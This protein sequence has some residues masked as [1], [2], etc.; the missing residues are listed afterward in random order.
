MA[1][2]SRRVGL[3]VVRLLIT[4]D[5]IPGRCRQGVP[6]A[7]RLH[8]AVPRG[9]GRGQRHLSPALREVHGDPERLS[10]AAVVYLTRG[11]LLKE[12]ALGFLWNGVELTDDNLVCVGVLPPAR[13]GLLTLLN[14]LDR[15]LT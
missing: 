6:A 3:R 11:G 1:S 13:L 2:G 15:L 10:R 8:G 7:A 12:N 14:P 9:S 4:T 5:T